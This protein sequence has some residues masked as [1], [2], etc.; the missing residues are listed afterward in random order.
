MAI[1]QPTGFCKHCNKQ[2]MA[3][4]TGVNHILHFLIAFFTCGA[5]ALVWIG[6]CIKLGGWKCSSCGLPVSSQTNKQVLPKWIQ[7]KH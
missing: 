1:Q 7:K 6:L 2:V 3:N 5:Q 4:R